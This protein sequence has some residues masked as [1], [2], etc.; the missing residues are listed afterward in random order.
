VTT[1]PAQLDVLFLSAR[2]L[3]PMDQGFCL[4]GGHMAEAL[5]QRALRVAIASIQP[6]PPD[7]P[8]WLRD[9]TVPWP[10]AQGQ[11]DLWLS[12]W[13]GPGSAARRR[14]A[15]YLGPP[16]SEMAGA[17][18]LLL[19]HRPAA[20]L[21]L[22]VRAPLL[23]RAL[24]GLRATGGIPPARL[25][26]YAADELTD[27]HLSCLKYQPMHAWPARLAL[28][29]QDAALQWLFARGLDGAIGVSPRQ[30]S[31]LQSRAGVCQAITIGNGVDLDYF[32]PR[33][34]SAPLSSPAPRSIIFWGR[35][36]FEPN[37]DAVCWFARAIWPIIHRHRPDAVWHILGHNPDPK[38]QQLAAIPGINLKGPVDDVRPWAHAAAAVV[39]PLRC[40]GGMKNKLLEAAALGR[41]I[42]ASP[43]AVE[44]L[45]FG[46]GTPPLLLCTRP[47]QWADAVLRI[48]SDKVQAA[49]LARRARL[50]VEENH[51][52]AAAA[53]TLASWLG[54]H[55]D[56]PGREHAVAPLTDTPSQSPSALDRAA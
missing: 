24:A 11:E 16:T 5:R 2:P 15:R 35:L 52:W 37:V 10:A 40:G 7:A 27:Y 14:M 23:L 28:L 3:W 39:L 18:A 29:A 42:V 53:A 56:S 34:T 54:L 6:C 55:A 20:V 51:T 25:I 31:L 13:S 50:W 32:T 36:D 21:G 30:T 8:A 45:C 4:H 33:P 47:Q 41:P 44:G 9:M 1:P 49:D 19:R 12:G 17:L 38:V 22:G 46:T 26:W 43:R 48:W